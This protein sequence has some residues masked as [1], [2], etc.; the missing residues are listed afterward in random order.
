VT[1]SGDG[2]TPFVNFRAGDGDAVNEI[3]RVQM[4]DCFGTEIYNNVFTTGSGPGVSI[5]FAGQI[6]DVRVTGL[7]TPGLDS[8]GSLIDDIEFGAIDPCPTPEPGSLLLIATSL[9][10]LAGSSRLRS[11]VA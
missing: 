6:H 11:L 8:S 7:G 2:Y 3:F 1:G 10:A 4:F 5:S 9:I